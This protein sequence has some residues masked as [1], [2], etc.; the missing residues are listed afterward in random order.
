MNCVF[1]GEMWLGV[2]T[3]H[4]AAA[5]AMHYPFLLV[6]VL[7]VLAIFSPSL[8]KKLFLEYL[9]RTRSLLGAGG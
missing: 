4:D 2:G 5:D 9:F 6:N 7:G 8:F 1:S 3:D